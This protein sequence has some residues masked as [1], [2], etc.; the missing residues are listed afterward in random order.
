MLFKLK[1]ERFVQKSCMARMPPNDLDAMEIAER[2]KQ[3]QKKIDPDGYVSFY[4]DEEKHRKKIAMQLL[5]DKGKESYKKWL[6]FGRLL[7]SPELSEEVQQ[8]L[9]ILNESQIKIPYNMEPFVYVEFSEDWG[10]EEGDAL[11]LQEAVPLFGK[12]DREQCTARKNKENLGYN[13][14]WFCILYL[15]EGQL[16]FYRGRQDFGDGDG[17]LFQHIEAQ[18]EFYLGEDGIDYLKSLPEKEAVEIRDNCLYVKNELL[19]TFKYFYNLT[20]IEKALVDEQRLNKTFPLE[21]EQHTAR[22]QYQEDLHAFVENSRKALC[23]GGE[24]PC[25]PDIRDYENTCSKK[26]YNEKVM[27]EIAEEAKECG[28]DVNEYAQNVYDTKIKKR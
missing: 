8:L 10:L 3:L 16:C 19:P 2:I 20:K 23:Y 28:M 24:L 7:E 5:V 9:K 25:M 12:L 18:Q 4:P 11:T 17:D 15:N 26:R 22:R 27:D 1:G 13:K 6:E 14:T 21:S